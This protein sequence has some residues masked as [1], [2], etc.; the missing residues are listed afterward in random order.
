[1]EVL[2]VAQR[3]SGRSRARC[4]ARCR[5]RRRRRA[6]CRRLAR[7]RRRR[8]ARA[9]RRA[10]ARRGSRVRGRGRCGMWR[11]ARGWS[12]RRGRRRSRS[13]ARRRRWCRRWR[14]GDLG[15]WLGRTVRA[16]RHGQLRRAIAGRGDGRRFACRT[17]DLAALG[18]GGEAESDSD[19]DDR[20]HKERGDHCQPALQRHGT[21]RAWLLTASGRLAREGRRDHRSLR[22]NGLSRSPRRADPELTQTRRG[23]HEPGWRVR[24]AAELDAI[25]LRLGPFPEWAARQATEDPHPDRVVD[26]RGQ[27]HA[28]RVVARSEADPD[29]DEAENDKRPDD[30]FHERRQPPDHR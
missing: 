16:R 28:T 4:G 5:C 10:R 24:G 20:E 8:G 1:M 11:W 12:R 21:V 22:W 19:S 23:H 14:D 13:R 3:A 26:D 7:C 2:A 29:R 15:R 18:P 25:G 9:R 6:R 17:A 30:P 27:A